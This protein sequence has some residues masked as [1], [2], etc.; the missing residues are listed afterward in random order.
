MLVLFSIIIYNTWPSKDIRQVNKKG[1]ITLGFGRCET[2]QETP[3]SY[4][5]K[6]IYIY[7]YVSPRVFRPTFEVERCQVFGQMASGC[8]LITAPHTPC[9]KR[10]FSDLE[11]P[12]GV[13]HKWMVVFWWEICVY[14][15]EAKCYFHLGDPLN[16]KLYELCVCQ[17]GVL[18]GS[19]RCNLW[20]LQK[21]RTTP[22]VYHLAALGF[23]RD[24]LGS[25]HENNEQD[26]VYIH[27]YV[28]AP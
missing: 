28:Y 25:L 10:G 21:Q 13:W 17:P 14:V 27:I 23:W 24:C 9:G 7:I 11:F 12:I 20:V 26:Y 3:G 16:H 15:A 4:I 6:V 18:Q 22:A 2:I 5:V 8:E 1:G 19:N